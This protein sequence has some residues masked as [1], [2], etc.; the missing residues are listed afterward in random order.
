VTFILLKIEGHVTF[1]PICKTFS[2]VGE[3][4]CLVA[5]LSIASDVTQNLEDH[6]INF[7]HVSALLEHFSAQEAPVGYGALLNTIVIL[8]FMTNS[9]EKSP[10]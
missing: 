5:T 2:L 4:Q 1:A 9:M 6:N 8:Y 10:S 7:T 3:Y